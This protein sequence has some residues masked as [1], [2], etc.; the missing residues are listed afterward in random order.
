MLILMV[1]KAVAAVLRI[2]SAIDEDLIR[3]S[4]SWRIQ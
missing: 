4:R 3:K 2:P 1:L